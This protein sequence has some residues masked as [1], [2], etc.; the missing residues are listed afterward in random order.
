MPTRSPRESLALFR[1]QNEMIQ[2]FER[3]RRG[4]R[5]TVEVRHVHRGPNHRLRA[6]LIPILT[7]RRRM[8]RF[9]NIA[10]T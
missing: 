10:N 3:Y 4:N 9:A 2:T 7:W 5:Q 8:S 1:L 6:R